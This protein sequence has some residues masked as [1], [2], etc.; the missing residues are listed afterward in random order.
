ME[1]EVVIIGGGPAGLTAALYTAR[2]QLAPLVIEG[3]QTGGQLMLTTMVENWPGVNVEGIMGSD[4]IQNIHKQAE[5]FGADFLSED[6]TEVDFSQKPFIIKTLNQTVK[7]KTVII[8]TGASARWLGLESEKALTGY[9][10]SSCATCD[11]AFFKDKVV[12]V[13]G[14]GDTAMEEALF[15][16]RFASH[17]H[18]LNR[19]SNFKASVI[20][21]ERAR[22]HEKITV[23]EN[24][25]VEK[26]ND[27]E[28]KKVTGMTLRETLTNKQ[29]ELA[30]DGV[31]IAIG[32]KPNTGLFDMLDKDDVG[33]LITD[34]VKTNV[35][36]V[37][38]CGDVQDS[39]YR[40]AITASG[41][42]CMAA[43]EAERWL[44]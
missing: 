32:H 42:G 39:K 13:V 12:T 18:I 19:S 6:V 34:G 28:T 9:G 36:G 41:S 4:L 44:G 8:S 14:G 30:C 15:L 3:Y 29:Y 38:A 1:R 16:T 26:I 5:H 22:A 24:V 37:F 2:A 35:P 7:A 21:L 20:M 23:H 31:F 40:Q 25:V 17:V 43:L 11:G 27:V 33:Y 10:V